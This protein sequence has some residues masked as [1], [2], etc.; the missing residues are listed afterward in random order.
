MGKEVDSQNEHIKR[1][2]RKV[3][4]QLCVHFAVG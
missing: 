4:L 3:S 2:T 1:I